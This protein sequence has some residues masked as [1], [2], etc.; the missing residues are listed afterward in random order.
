M[1]PEEAGKSLLSAAVAL[2]ETESSIDTSG[3]VQSCKD[4]I[5]TL[6]SKC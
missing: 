1:W 5:G 4:L 2:L 3:M 6:A